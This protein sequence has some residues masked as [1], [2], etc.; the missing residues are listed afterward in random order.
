[1]IWENT[2]L[3]LKLYVR[4]LNAISGMI[5]EGH[6][7]F[8]AVLV[9]GI[10][11]LLQF[12][13]TSKIYDGYEA[14][15]VQPTQQQRS[16][17]QNVAGSPAAI[18]T[19][20]D[21]TS[22]EDAAYDEDEPMY[23]RRP[24]PVVGDFGWHFISF[25]PFSFFTIVAGLMLLYVPATVLVASLLEP[26]GSFGV[27]FRRDY[28]TLL[29]C[30]L[31][32]WA[33]AHL[34]FAIAGFALEPLHRGAGTA[35]ALWVGS[36]VAFGFLMVFAIR[37]VFGVPYLKAIATVCISWTALL[38]QERLFSVVSPFLFSPFILI[39]AYMYLRGGIGDISFSLKQRQN[40]SRYLEAA[41]INPRDAEAHYQLGLVNLRRRQFA[42]ATER[43]K[44][45][46]EIDGNETDA[47][48]QLG[49][50][51]REQNRLPE[52]IE[53]LGRVVEQDEKHAHSEVWREIGAT[54]LSAGMYAEAN[55]AFERYIERRP[56]DA[57]GLFYYGKT[58]N[59]LARSAEAQE[60]FRRCVEAVKTTPSYRRR[61][62]AKWRKLAQAQISGDGQ[63]APSVAV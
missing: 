2:K 42:E 48:F 46:I 22:E 19:S 6:W 54:Y 10:S 35:L 24:L 30:T 55:D 25:E 32:A 13:V 9:V 38:V 39:Y 44:R 12:T 37:V 31:A 34:P 4:P 17:P 26:M 59:Q 53:Y 36:V 56:Y 5:D 16:E 33:A 28:G 11:M 40:F 62:M 52:A 45:A 63:K 7:I 61:Q 49:R 15:E 8:G 29:S 1:M 3:F 51:A 58:L 14:V 23:E 27:I 60:M 18:A 20:Q 50:I 43:F 41:T 21:T 57:E 47:Y